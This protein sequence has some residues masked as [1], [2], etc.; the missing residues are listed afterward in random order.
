VREWPPAA[1]PAGQQQELPHA[2]LEPVRS[3]SLRV[4]PEWQT[5]LLFPDQPESEK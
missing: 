3:P 4:Q 1:G 5:R 2:R